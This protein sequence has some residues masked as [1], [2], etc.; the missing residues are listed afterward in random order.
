MCH[1]HHSLNTYMA[2]ALLK[3]AILMELTSKNIFAIKHEVTKHLKKSF[4]FKYFME[5]APVIKISLEL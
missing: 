5:N 1:H 2:G 3:S 4:S